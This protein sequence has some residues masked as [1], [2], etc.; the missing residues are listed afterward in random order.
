M[1]FIEVD[2]EVSP[3]EQGCDVLITELSYI[4]FDTFQQNTKGF[5]AY[6][7]K[8]N[9]VESQLTDLIKHYTDIFAISF[10]IKEIPQQNW[11]AGW[12]SNFD[13]ININ[14]ICYVRAPFH[15]KLDGFKYDVV[16][17]PKMSFGTGHHDTTQLMIEELLM[18]N[19]VNQS[20]LDMGCGTGVLAI[21]A[22][23]MG[24]NS[25]LA[26]D[27]D[28]WSYENTLENLQ[29][30]NIKNVSV[31]KGNGQFLHKKTFNTILANINKNVLMADMN[32]YVN[33]LQKNG[34]LVMS[35][36][37]E[38]DIDQ[39]IE[40]AEKLGLKLNNK[41]IKNQWTMLHFIN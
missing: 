32:L 5:K 23:L 16:I 13:P 37:F 4:G 29:K 34:N 36:F 2:F 24:A 1:N 11:N 31:Y 10:T 28:Q 26:I 21:V 7:N 33:S 15:A 19:I 35:G 30:N 6:S 41:K 12:E 14:N 9:F 17:E 22:S 27:I 20:V 18:L 39:I 40:S 8:E 3:L 25:I 38:T